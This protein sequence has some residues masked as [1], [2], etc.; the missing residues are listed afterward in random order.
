VLQVV[1]PTPGG[2]VL[3]VLPLHPVPLLLEDT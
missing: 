3:L 2:L 1:V